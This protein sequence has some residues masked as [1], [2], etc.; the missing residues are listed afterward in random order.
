MP[1]FLL[2]VHLIIITA[3]GQAIVKLTISRLKTAVTIVLQGCSGG[4]ILR[5]VIVER[6]CP[7]PVSGILG[8]LRLLVAH[9]TS[10]GGI[11]KGLTLLVTGLFLDNRA[12]ELLTGG[13]PRR[14][15][16][17]ADLAKGIANG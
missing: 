11:T 17:I 12:V 8:G 9:I 6:R 1:P 16:D 3:I 2:S 10:V 5:G 15:I 14:V 13:I 4:S 7:L